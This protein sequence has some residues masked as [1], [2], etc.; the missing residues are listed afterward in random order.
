[1][2]LNPSLQLNLC[3]IFLSI[4][5]ARNS[6]TRV[7]VSD[8]ILLFLLYKDYHNTKRVKKSSAW[9][10]FFLLSYLFWQKLDIL[11]LYLENTLRNYHIDLH[12]GSREQKG[13]NFFCKYD[14]IISLMLI[15]LL[16]WHPWKLQ[17]AYTT[18][19][20]VPPAK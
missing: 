7:I 4:F 13:D 12:F 14:A 16:F 2:F 10:A 19:Q 1:M 18:Q 8:E 6:I 15:S 3:L 9:G 17:W 11:N 20:C 5:S